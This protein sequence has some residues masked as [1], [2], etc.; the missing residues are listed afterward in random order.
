MAKELKKARSL[1]TKINNELQDLDILVSNKSN[2]FCDKW[3]GLFNKTSESERVFVG[4]FPSLDHEGRMVE[5]LNILTEA[6]KKIK[7]LR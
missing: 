4:N 3:E 1:F 7:K 5:M 6:H 2:D